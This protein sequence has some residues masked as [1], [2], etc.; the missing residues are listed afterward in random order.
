MPNNEAASDSCGAA[1]PKMLVDFMGR[2]TEAHKKE[3]SVK[4]K[5]PDFR[6]T[7]IAI[8]RK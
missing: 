4:T 2:Q 8:A 7:E 5:R 1:S 3:Y 6:K